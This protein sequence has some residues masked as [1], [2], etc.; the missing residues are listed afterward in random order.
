MDRSPYRGNSWPALAFRLI[1]GTCALGLFCWP[2]RATTQFSA[3]N[4]NLTMS[5]HIVAV[6]QSCSGS[7]TLTLTHFS[8]RS[9][10][11]SVARLGDEILSNG[12]NALQ[13]SYKITG[14][15][16]SNPDAGW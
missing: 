8:P 4:Y 13:T 7:T 12:T 10:H 5:S 1:S 6:G 14:A 3:P 16:L 15:A 9:L 2:A 11:V